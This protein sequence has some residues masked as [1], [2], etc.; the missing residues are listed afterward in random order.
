M[1]TKV[2]K[3]NAREKCKKDYRRGAA[4]NLKPLVRSSE[5]AC[6]LLTKDKIKIMLARLRLHVCERTSFFFEV[7]R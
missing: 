7:M 5:S 1:G 3:T 6:R 4:C 2:L